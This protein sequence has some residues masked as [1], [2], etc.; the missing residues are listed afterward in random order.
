MPQSNYLVE[1]N[2]YDYV[3]LLGIS[4]VAVFASIDE[5]YDAKRSFENKKRLTSLEK[6]PPAMRA[7]KATYYGVSSYLKSL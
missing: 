6:I 1:F 2:G 4:V 5:A 7:A 3:V